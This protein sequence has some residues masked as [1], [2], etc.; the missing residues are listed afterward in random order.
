MRSKDLKGVLGLEMS[1]AWGC[2]FKVSDKTKGA[3]CRELLPAR[4]C[5]QHLVWVLGWV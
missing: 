1:R 4:S 3:S 2:K 5:F